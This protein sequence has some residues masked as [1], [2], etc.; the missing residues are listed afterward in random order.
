[1]NKIY[2]VM[3]PGYADNGEM[4]RKLYEKLSS[5]C[6]VEECF[7]GTSRLKNVTAIL[8]V[9]DGCKIGIE[10]QGGKRSRL[11][12]SLRRFKEKGCTEIFCSCSTSGKT[13]N[14]VK[15]M[16]PDYEVHFIEEDSPDALLR[17]AQNL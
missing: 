3:K 4:L 13:K 8:F 2:A 6:K 15:K 10:T 7:P 12:D 1:M 5:K 11:E 9:H 14:L 16:E 17:I